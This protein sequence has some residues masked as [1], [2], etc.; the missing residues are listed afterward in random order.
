[1]IDSP[2]VDTNSPYQIYHKQ[3]NICDIAAHLYAELIS[4][5]KQYIIK[6]SISGAVESLIADI[7]EKVTLIK[8]ELDIL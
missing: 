3:K 7:K 8:S 2:M 6:D 1:M 4:Y 5:K